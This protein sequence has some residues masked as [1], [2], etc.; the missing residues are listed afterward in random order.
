MRNK[1]L[2]VLGLFFMAGCTVHTKPP[3]FSFEVLTTKETRYEVVALVEQFS[4][5]ENLV[6]SKNYN[7]PNPNE[8]RVSIDFADEAQQN[9]WILVNNGNLKNSDHLQ[10][11]IYPL[12]NNNTCEICKKFEAS[13]ELKL[14]QE[15]FEI[16][17][18]V[19]NGDW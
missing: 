9:A 19:K 6:Q 3:A 1:F 2:V 17:N 11:Y 14:I 12:G 13:S 16:K 18:I 4:L 15:K 8:D 7:I 10:V 5:R